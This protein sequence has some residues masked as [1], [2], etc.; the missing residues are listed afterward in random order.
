MNK[1]RR[2]KLEDIA[3]RL[4]ILQGD[5]YMLAEEEREYYDNMPESIQGGERGDKA[6]EI[7]DW[8]EE[9]GCAIDEIADT[10]KAAAE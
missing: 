9:A 7:A 8:L 10:V 3:S 5:L 6:Q 1:D 4:E 2:K